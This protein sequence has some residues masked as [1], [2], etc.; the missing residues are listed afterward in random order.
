MPRY[1][2]IRLA[3]TSQDQLSELERDELKMMKT[4]IHEETIREVR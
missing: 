4:N 3:N 2:L 1:Y